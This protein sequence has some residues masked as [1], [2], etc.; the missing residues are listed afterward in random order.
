MDHLEEGVQI[1]L[2]LEC[3]TQIDFL[4]TEIR[5]SFILKASLKVIFNP[6]AIN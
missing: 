6:P 5:F 1:H 3:A 2:V 4:D